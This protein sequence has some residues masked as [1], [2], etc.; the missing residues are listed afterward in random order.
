M[1]ASKQPG[2]E[3]FGAVWL[4]DTLFWHPAGD[5]LM[6]PP[7]LQRCSPRPCTSSRTLSPVDFAAMVN[8]LACL[9]F[10]LQQ[11]REGGR[12]RVFTRR[13]WPVYLTQPREVEGGAERQLRG[14][15]VMLLPPPCAAPVESHLASVLEA[16]AAP[17]AA[18]ETPG[19]SLAVA[20][21]SVGYIAAAA[22]LALLLA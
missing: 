21:R 6:P 7:H 3:Q 8:C 9:A 10:Y 11:L 16:A 19:V 20:G 17:N 4:C 1:T 18:K 12:L 22:A 2:T 13:S 5:T 14:A 15:A